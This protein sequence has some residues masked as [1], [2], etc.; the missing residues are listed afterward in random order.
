V[1]PL[2]SKFMQRHI[3]DAASNNV[4][5]GQPDQLIPVAGEPPQSTLNPQATGSARPQPSAQSAN[6][7]VPGQPPSPQQ[8][9]P[10][11]SERQRP[12]GLHDELKSF[13]GKL[14]NKKDSKVE[15]EDGA[16]QWEMIQFARDLNL[17]VEDVREAKAQFDYHD[18]NN[19]KHLDL[20][21]F[22]QAVVKLMQDQFNGISERRVKAVCQKHWKTA[23]KDDSGTIDLKEFM[24]WYAQNRFKQVLMLTDSQRKLRE[25]ARANG[26]SDKEVE[27]I[28]Q[29]Y[30][31]FDKDGSG[32]IDIHEFK[33]ILYSL[34]KIPPEIEL[35]KSRIDFFWRE[36]DVDQSGQASFDEFL[37]WWL[38]RSATLMPYDDFYRQIR[39]LLNVKYDPP[40]YFQAANEAVEE[41]LAEEEVHIHRGATADMSAALASM[42]KAIYMQ[43]L[44]ELEEEEGRC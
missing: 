35:P 40:A 34:M 32:I 5:A 4:F 8:K 31:A 44:A 15:V 29:S 39:C 19:D 24:H 37:T 11:G 3:M 16:K 41:A 30:D 17:R 18:I 43:Q 1:P 14:T 9:K 2:M 21:E 26:V 20:N 25:L 10:K 27:E 13:V 6:P 22:Q 42:E 12:T 23:D 38:R 28:K 36:I 7:S 33:H